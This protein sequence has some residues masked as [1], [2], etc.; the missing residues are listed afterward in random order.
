MSTELYIDESPQPFKS[1][2]LDFNSDSLAH[3]LNV[4]LPAPISISNGAI[5]VLLNGEDIFT[6]WIDTSSTR[7]QGEQSLQCRSRLSDLLDS[8]LTLSL[9]DITLK[10]YA[11]AI[12]SNF[13]LQLAYSLPVGEAIAEIVIAAEPPLDSLTQL[14]RQAGGVIREAGSGTML[15]EPLQAGAHSGFQL[16]SQRDLKAPLEKTYNLASRYRTW[17]V[18]TQALP[19]TNG[20]S[21]LTSDL[22]LIMAN[23]DPDYIS[24]LAT[25]DLPRPRYRQITTDGQHSAAAAQKLAEQEKIRAQRDALSF[26]A[27]LA[28]WTTPTGEVWQVNHLVN[29]DGTDRLIIGVQ[30]QASK[31][32]GT[33]TALKL[34]VAA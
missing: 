12:A 22:P 16:D 3:A 11:E 10:Q 6:G 8:Q 1:L 21:R 18:R 17:E 26:R 4:S 24:S 33:T 20:Q 34:A 28:G 31:Q 14:C 2:T 19:E 7:G 15:I 30:L 25:T 23:S 13:E 27:Q 29:L 9:Q 32:G 5:K